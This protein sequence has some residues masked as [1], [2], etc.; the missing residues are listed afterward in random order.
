MLVI[1]RKLGVIYVKLNQRILASD[2][3]LWI[4][5]YRIHL[6]VVPLMPLMPASVY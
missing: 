6:S 3:H 1:A 4:F 5:S 2:S